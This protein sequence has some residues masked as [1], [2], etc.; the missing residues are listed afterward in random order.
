MDGIDRRAGLA[1][2]EREKEYLTGCIRYQLGTEEKAGLEEFGV[3]SG[4]PP[5]KIQWV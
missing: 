3:R 1:L 2:D 5:M 4:L